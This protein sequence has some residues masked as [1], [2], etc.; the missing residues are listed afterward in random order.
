[1]GFGL[2]QLRAFL[3]VADQLHFGRAAQQLHVSQPALSQQIRLLERDIGASLFV[4]TSRMVELT[5]AGRALAEAAPRVILE[6]DRAERR[7][8]QAA[9]G[10]SGMLVIGS[11]NTALASITPRIM[12]A[13]R[14]EKPDLRMELYHMDTAA[15]LTALADRR[16]DMAVV[17]EA[18]ATR[19]LATEQ[20][21][22]EPLAVVL[23]EGHSLADREVVDPAALADEEFVLWPR[24]LGPDFFDVIIA[25][26]RRQGFNPRIVAE[27]DDVETQLGLV[28]AG[29]GVSLQPA[30]YAGVRRVGVVF[31]PLQGAVPQVA[32]QLAW[33]RG[34]A[35]P[36]VAHFVT[37]ARRV[38]AGAWDHT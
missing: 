11:V 35:S 37:V 17:R 20:L 1:M 23:P 34:E 27:G 28:A 16:I 13:V 19:D 29:A 8:E 12:R 22:S 4:R 26:C 31:R 38:A 7:V 32:L 24:V 6:V 3:A 5:P 25:Y 21:A 36:A 30:Y 15:Q 33:R 14:A 9:E 18:N 10:S 2:H